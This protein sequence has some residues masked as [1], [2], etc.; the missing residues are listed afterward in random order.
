MNKQTIA[1]LATVIK[2]EHSGKEAI[3]LSIWRELLKKD[4]ISVHDNFFELGGDS[5]LALQVVARARKQGVKFSPKALMD[6][7]TISELARVSTEK[8]AKT[9]LA[10]TAL[11]TEPF[12][13]LPTQAWFF[14]QEFE[15]AEHWNQ[16][17]M[18][19][20]PA[21][22]NKSDVEQAIAGLCERHPALN[23]AFALH[24]TQWQQRYVEVT[25]K[26][27]NNIAPFF[28]VD[29][30]TFA[31]VNQAIELAAN[32]AQASVSFEK[33]FKAVWFEAGNGVAHLLLIAHHLV[34][35]GVSWRIILDDLQTS[36]VNIAK[37]AQS[38]R[39]NMSPAIPDAGFKVWVDTLLAASTN[40][41]FSAELDYWLTVTGKNQQRLPGN[42]QGDN[43]LASRKR[44]SLELDADITEQLLS[45]APQ[46]YRTQINDVLLAALTPA[47]CA[48]SGYDEALVEL[49]GHGRETLNE[50]LDISQTV[51]WF[52]SLY[53]VRLTNH[54]NLA[55]LLKGVKETLRQV[56]NNGLG[57]GVLRYLTDEG[58]VL[59]DN[60]YPQVTFNY[61]G[62][63]DQ[64]VNQD[65]SWQ[66]SKAPKGHERSLLS[67][68]RTWLDFNLM[69]YQGQLRISVNYSHEIHDEAQITQLLTDYVETLT[70]LITHCTSGEV[71]VTPS[72]FPLAALNQTSLDSLTLPVA[73][74]ADLY[75]LSPMQSGMY[76]HSLYDDSSISYVNQLKLN[77]EG[78]DIERFKAAWQFVLDKHDILRTGFITQAA[79]SLQWVAKHVALPCI[80]QDVRGQQG[81]D[82]ILESLAAAQLSEGFDLTQPPLMKIALVRV[83]DSSWHFIW[84]R[85]HIL[86]DGWSTSL[87]LGDVM[88]HYTGKPSISSASRYRDYI[89]WLSL[90]DVQETQAFWTGQLSTLSSPTFLAGC[91][92]K[93]STV[94][95]DE[96]VGY[97]S[98]K[99]ILD[100]EQTQQLTHFAQ[101]NR[102]TMNTLIQGVWS[103]LLS[104]YSG[105]Q[106]IAFG[107]TVAGRPSDIAGIDTLIGLFINTLPV[108][109][110]VSAEQGIGDWLR[111]LQEQNLSAREHEYTSLTDIHRWSEHGAQGVFDSIVVFENYPVDD[112]LQSSTPVGVAFS[113]LKN[114]EETNYPLTL[115]VG[116]RDTVVIDF[117]YQTGVFDNQHIQVISQHFNQVVKQLIDAKNDCIGDIALLSKAE[118]E[119]LLAI[120]SNEISYEQDTLVHELIEQQALSTPN[121]IA[122]VFEDE[123]LTYQALNARANQ[124]AHYLIA[125][126]VQPE[127]TVGIAVERSVEMVVGLLAILKVGG[128]YVP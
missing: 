53:P 14:E 115:V 37:S 29:V 9:S 57:Y 62:Q 31:D 96:A 25:N 84:T 104:R 54:D 67:K 90:R 125:Q 56:P 95:V 102:I 4:K 76:F 3:L 40:S 43:T 122:L 38:S 112:A 23:M 123:T 118:T 5:I 94:S 49:E 1:E 45:S 26:D 7:Q 36:Y 126:G 20:V 74:V 114:Y 75:P 41:T 92:A 105:Q 111:Q 100:V 22:T 6:K 17:V 66:V 47:L 97:G 78:L 28:C 128:A 68:R 85:H 87:L 72:D 30:S 73:N 99:L 55:D 51:G 12:A 33:P 44:V 8:A 13:L 79:H 101:R 61:L 70:A 108:V 81:I 58:Q 11:T 113:A 120:G 19:D 117:K 121:G 119:A 65:N 2:T 24:D 127:D 16:S 48:F 91:F 52:T 32:D 88:R 50:A 116:A 77:I 109:T 86:L 98:E 83:S 18:L 34:V 107:A 93:H 82:S 89:H 103:L 124:L 59:A 60:A 42:A 21:G 106:T 110:R 35:D 27:A 69:M 15:R 39:T 63:F 46:A 80:E 64:S 10:T 71:G